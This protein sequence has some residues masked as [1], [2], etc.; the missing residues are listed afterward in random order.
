MT[1]ADSI[2]WAARAGP[3]CSTTDPQPAFAQGIMTAK[4]PHFVLFS[5]TTS[6]LAAADQSRVPERVARRTEVSRY[7][8][9]VLRSPDGETRLEVADAEQDAS[10]ERLAL[11]AV[12]RGLEALEQPSRVTLVTT[13]ASIRRGLRFGL[14]TWRE[15]QWQWERYGRMAPIK[16]ADLWQ[17]VDR[18]LRFH[19]VD[20]R[21]LRFDQGGDDLSQPVPRSLVPDRAG[22]QRQWEARQ[23]SLTASSHALPA[24]QGGHNRLQPPLTSH[25]TP[26]TAPAIRLVPAVSIHPWTSDCGTLIC[27]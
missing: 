22:Q 25:L 16:N 19:D 12:V 23:A 24:A 10:D 2:R 8:H 20:C 14:D 6:A 17:R 11:L 7:W 9:F 3:D 26:A 18:A 15:N 27:R 1:A 21:T 5:E 13:S 4:A